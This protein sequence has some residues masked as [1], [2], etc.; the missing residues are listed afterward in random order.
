MKRHLEALAQVL[1]AIVADDSIEPGERV[2]R[3]RQLH[4]LGPLSVKVA[5]H[6]L[7]VSVSSVSAWEKHRRGVL[8]TRTACPPSTSHRFRVETVIRIP[9]DQWRPT[10]TTPGAFRL[11]RDIPPEEIAAAFAFDPELERLP[12]DEEAGWKLGITP[13]TVVK[14]RRSGAVQTMMGEE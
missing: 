4:P 10:V 6:I 2:R 11:V 3:W 9:P 7:D 12:N 8:A 5:A 14:L 13:A 1:A